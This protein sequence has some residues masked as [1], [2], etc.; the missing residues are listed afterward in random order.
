MTAAVGYLAQRKELERVD[1]L[2]TAQGIPYAVMKGA[3]VRECVYP[4]PSLRPSSDIDILV[5]PADRQ[6]A[7]RILLDDGFTVHVKPDGVSHEATFSRGL[8]DIDLHWNL[9]RPG[10]SRVELTEGLL[11]RRQRVN[12]I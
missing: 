7:A 6:R 2:F 8:T 1:E 3:H 9:L 11:A 10:R 12:G 5:S 4:D